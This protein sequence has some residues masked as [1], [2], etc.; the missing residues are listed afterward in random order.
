[1]E[2]NKSD[3][4]TTAYNDYIAEYAPVKRDTPMQASAD[5]T[6]M[7]LT[8][9]AL[10]M[11]EYQH[12][13]PA[14]SYDLRQGLLGGGMDMAQGQ[15]EKG[16]GEVLR[17]AGFDGA[18][19]KMLEWSKQNV[20][21]AM[22]DRDGLVDDVIFTA[23][24]IAV[25]LAIAGAAAAAAPFIGAT[26]VVG[27][28]L[29]GFAAAWGMTAGD[30]FMK[31]EEL[32]EDYEPNVED[33]AITALLALPEAVGVLKG[34]KLLKPFADAVQG[35]GTKAALK[36]GGQVDPKDVSRLGEY[37]KSFVKNFAQQ[38]AIEGGQDFTGSLTANI[39]TDTAID[40][41]RLIS[42]GK[43]AA[44]EGLIGGIFGGPLGTAQTY[45]SRVA[46]EE[47]ELAQQKMG[48]KRQ[49]F[50]NLKDE[51]GNL[52]EDYRQLVPVQGAAKNPGMFTLGA[53]IM[54][55][56]ATDRM[57]Q[58]FGHYPKV[59]NILDNFNAKYKERQVGQRTINEKSRGLEG[60]FHTLAM[61]FNKGTEQNRKDAWDAVA[62][63]EAL[64]TPEYRSLTELLHKA[65]PEATGKASVDAINTKEGWLA[66]NTYLPT[67]VTMDFKKMNDMEWGALKTMAEADLVAQKLSPKE[68]KS[69]LKI[70][71]QSLNSYQQTG[72]HL[73]FARIGE[74]TK[75]IQ[76][77][78]NRMDKYQKDGKQ[79]SDKQ[80]K[81][82][83]S[84]MAKDV[85]GANRKSPIVLDRMLGRFSQ[86]FLNDFRKNEDPR[87]ALNAH[88]RMVSEHLAMVE[89]FGVDNVLFDE[90][91]IEAVADTYNDALANGDVTKAMN[92][93][94]VEKMYDIL[95]TQQR[96]H[97][98]PLQSEKVRSIQNNTRAVANTMLLGLSALVSIPEALVIFMNTGGKASLQGLAQTV[99]QVSKGRHEKVGLASEQL[100]YTIRTA[101]D[102]A[103][104]RTGEE[105]FEVS[106]WENTFI[107]WTGLP[108]LQH[109]LTVWAA[110][111]NDVH[112]KTMTK[113][114]ATDKDPRSRAYKSAMI[115]EAGLDVDQ[116]LNWAEGDFSE[117]SD[118]FK[119]NYIPAVVGLTHD[120]IVDP[121]PIDKPLWMNNEHLLLLTQLKGFMT[122]FTNRVMVKW[123]KNVAHQP[124]GNITLATKVA[125]YVAMYIAAQIGMQ[126]VR[127]VLKTGDLDDWDD[128]EIEDRIVMAFGYIG[129]MGYFVDFYSS[130][131]HRSDPLASI[132]GPVLSKSL[133]SSRHLVNAVEQQDPEAFVQKMAKEL[134]PNMPGKD[135]I[136][137]AFGAE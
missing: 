120:T 117:D 60:E 78:M 72:D 35:A 102:H 79:I 57:R 132:G 97:L 128:K 13:A 84:S 113:E 108:Y 124:A 33:W 24:Q 125:P 112:L 21:D 1:M 95:R 8:P 15:M 17:M 70:L 101:I 9:M 7:P 3:T 18:S 55:G 77:V 121:H 127:E 65:I 67:M 47:A 5:M 14:P 73:S 56:N 59:K 22:V 50:L 69:Q 87:G 109:F 29:A 40:A 92:A 133:N 105:S 54:V 36:A 31:E 134:F 52:S 39:R 10:A 116:M 129:S 88:I 45:K 11:L 137:E 83:K 28:G 80:R 130:L 85:K 30:F 99:R 66:D 123:G 51:D 4:Q 63:G 98:K 103:I 81:N 49:E 34:A 107:R 131:L 94:D 110:R 91:M 114:L 42:V 58:K 6:G 90:A 19:E 64:D 20:D 62:N 48:E 37:S 96:I 115:Q 23:G 75:G 93:A 2:L 136:L 71:K 16:V 25:P 27:S 106:A 119:K 38:G 86:K 53:T 89:T 41:E 44:Y 61:D 32:D 74:D 26:A 100:G 46:R 43:G 126:A 76:N 12:D 104:N 122:V 118:F 111:A 68:V 135:L 82:L